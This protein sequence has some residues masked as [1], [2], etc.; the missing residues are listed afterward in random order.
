MILVAPTAFKGTLSARQVADAIAAGIQHARPDAEFRLLPVSDGGNGL[1]DSLSGSVTAE[2]LTRHVSDPLGRQVD[3]RVLLLEQ[4]AERSGHVGRAGSR[5]AARLEPPAAPGD[6]RPREP[7]P[8]AGRIAVLESADACGL[9]LLR[10]DERDPLRVHTRGVGELLSAAMR[11]GCD[12][13][14]LGLGGSATVDGGVGMARALGWSFIDADGAP[15]AD[16]GA[17][18]RRLHA[19]EP[20]REQE[21]L[22]PVVALCDVLNPL[23]GAEGAAAVYA[24]QKGASDDDVRVLEAGLE[25]LA[26]VVRRDLNVDVAQRPGAGAAG[27]LGAGCAAFLG[28]N[29]VSGSEWILQRLRFDD[30]VHH[31]EL[32]VTGEGAYDRQSAM[33]KVTG[34]VIEAAGRA[35]V[36]VLLVAGRVDVDLPPGATA[37]TGP[38]LDGAAIARL[39]A[40]AL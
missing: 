35:G 38:D 4:S 2:L 19:A 3:A 17:G 1:I 24:P 23:V 32:V 13:M 5:P 10:A 20:P 21:L 40:A 12:R 31:A 28:A 25:Q 11:V 22:P 34:R 27:G 8:D 18:L 33:G 29:L 16:G 6:P 37:V 26:E 15:I 39:V 36:P 7:A 30:A 14:V 9:H